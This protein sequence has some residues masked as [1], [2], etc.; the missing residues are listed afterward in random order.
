[1]SDTTSTEPTA[2][3]SNRLKGIL[4]ALV[5]ILSAGAGAYLV[6][7]GRVVLGTT[8]ATERNS[9]SF[10]DVAFIPLQ[11]LTVAIGSNSD[12]RFLRFRGELEVDK[13]FQAQIEAQ[14]PRVIDVLNTYLQSL[15]L[16]EIESPSSL[17]ALRSQMRRRV[18]LVVGGD[19]INDLLIMEFVVN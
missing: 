15:E 5:L 18:D 14:I 17:L 10:A 13:R 1:M 19:R 3:K 7:S 6:T 4:V 9:E 12:R 8:A 16:G 2:R 11:P